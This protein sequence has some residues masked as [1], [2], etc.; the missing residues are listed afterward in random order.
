MP[1]GSIR[2][3]RSLVGPGAILLLSTGDV[4]RDEMVDIWDMW[5]PGDAGDDDS[6]N[7]EGGVGA[8]AGAGAV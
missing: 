3:G 7:G 1:V 4:W 6:G 8:R 5:E 2:C